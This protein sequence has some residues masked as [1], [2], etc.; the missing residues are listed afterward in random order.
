MTPSFL[1]LTFLMMRIGL[2]GMRRRIVDYDPALGIDT[3]HLVLTIAGFLIAL[4]VLIFLINFFYSMKHGEKAEGISGTPARRNGRCLRRCRR[5]IMTPD[6]RWSVSRTI[7]ACRVRTY[8][9]FIRKRITGKDPYSND[10]HKTRTTLRQGVL[11]FVYLA[12]LTPLN[13]LWLPSMRFPC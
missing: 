13:T 12:V 5:I 6:S 8:V 7:T 3:Y 1:V 2:L 4:S 10:T 11:I 9:K